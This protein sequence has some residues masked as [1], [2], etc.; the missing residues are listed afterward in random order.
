MCQPTFLSMRR[1]GFSGAGKDEW[2]ISTG[3]Q[4]RRT[5]HDHRGFDGHI[6]D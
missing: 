3:E 2:K 1:G 5:C 6:V 4:R